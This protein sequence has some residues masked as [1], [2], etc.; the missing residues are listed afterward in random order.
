MIQS[1][2]EGHSCPD[3]GGHQ[4]FTSERY[5]RFEGHSGPD[6]GGFLLVGII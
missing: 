1:F 4:S 5:S 3:G 6:G 2:L